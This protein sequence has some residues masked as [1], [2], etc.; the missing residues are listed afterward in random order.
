MAIS[1]NRFCK[2]CLSFQCR[3]R[4]HGMAQE[5]DAQSTQGCTQQMFKV[6]FSK[7]RGSN[8]ELASDGMIPLRRSSTKTSVN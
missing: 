2:I 3:L 1:D 6:G 4:L 5:Q 8:A 7:V